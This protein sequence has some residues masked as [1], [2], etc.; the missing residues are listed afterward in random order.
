MTLGDAPARS[1]VDVA[2]FVAWLDRVRQAVEAHNDWNTAAER[3]SVM[4]SIETARAEF[5]ARQKQ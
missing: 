5:V 2:Y 3:A 4:K 1:A